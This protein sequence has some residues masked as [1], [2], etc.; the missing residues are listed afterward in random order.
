MRSGTRLSE[1]TRKP[2]GA[3]R[4]LNDVV[5]QL[6]DAMDD[7]GA[8]GYRRATNQYRSDSLTLEAFDKGRKALNELPENIEVF[9]ANAPDGEKEA[10]VAGL[11]RQVVREAEPGATGNVP[12]NL[13]KIFRG[14]RSEVLRQALGKE[15]FEAFRNRLLKELEF[16]KT[17]GAVLG[18]SPTQPRQRAAAEQFERLGRLQRAGAAIREGRGVL[19]AAAEGLRAAQPVGTN[20]EQNR[21]LA[22]L[23]FRSQGQGLGSQRFAQGQTPL[24]ELLL[25]QGMLQ[26]T[27]GR[28]GPLAR[29]AITAGGVGA[30]SLAPQVLGGVEF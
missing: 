27:A 24:T 28:V 2:G 20:P 5:Q 10:F 3:S 15:G 19:G 17:S 29:S 6:T 4:N 25:R 22:Q 8:E 12:V 13:R 26:G 30:G 21:A 11:A 9:L 16:A 7:A 18:G 23:L 14:E 1:K